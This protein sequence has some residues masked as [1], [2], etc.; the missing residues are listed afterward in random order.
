MTEN[1]GKQAEAVL[2]GAAEKLMRTDK[3]YRIRRP[4]IGGHV[5]IGFAVVYEFHPG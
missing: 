2:T 4:V 1:A 3:G 5:S